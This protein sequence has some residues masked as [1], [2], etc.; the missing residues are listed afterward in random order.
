M[1]GRL[2]PRDVSKYTRTY[3]RVT[4]YYVDR[5]EGGPKSLAHIVKFGVEFQFLPHYWTVVP[6]WRVALRALNQTRVLPDFVCIG[7]LKSGTSSI[8]T[9]LFRH[10][11]IVP[12]LTKEI[13]A[14]DPEHWRPHYPTEEEMAEVRKATG[15]ALTGYFAPR[16]QYLPLVESFKKARPHGK[17]ILVL[18]N[19][20]DRAYSHFGWE[21]LHGGPVVKQF[22]YFGSYAEFVDLALNMYPSPPP[23]PCGF[24]FLQ[25][26]IYDTAVNKWLKELGEDRVLIVTADEYFADNPGT[27]NRIYDFLGLSGLLPVAH[28]NVNENPL[29]FPSQDERSRDRLREFYAPWNARLYEVLGRDL[30][31]D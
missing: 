16:L 21:H 3:Q 31:W 25:A 5:I 20:V 27:M 10:P 23:S 30:G 15:N 13:Y 1:T 28:A 22:K 17:A 8:T 4:D 24:P 7:S 6:G 26:G 29:K 19:P 18:R 2:Q 9:D 11:S 12:P 14:E